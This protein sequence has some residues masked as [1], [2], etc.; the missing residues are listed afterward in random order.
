MVALLHSDRSKATMLRTP[1]PASG[2]VGGLAAGHGHQ[3]G[4]VTPASHYRPGPGSPAFR[5]LREADGHRG[6]VRPAL[7]VAGRPLDLRLD[8][9]L[10]EPRRGQEVVV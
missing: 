9:A 7:G 3:L 1:E 4:P 10:G 5:P 8:G 6:V 2:D